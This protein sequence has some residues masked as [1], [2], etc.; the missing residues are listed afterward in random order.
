[1]LKIIVSVGVPLLIAVCG[2]FVLYGGLIRRQKDHCKYIKNL[3]HSLWDDK[4]RP[5]LQSI[6]GCHEIRDELKIL[7]SNGFEKMER[8]AEQREKV[9][10]DRFDQFIAIKTKIEQLER[11]K[12]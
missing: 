5:I 2:M 6:D 4:G 12:K 9:W 8:I 7:I 1:M 3:N 10:N 11:Y